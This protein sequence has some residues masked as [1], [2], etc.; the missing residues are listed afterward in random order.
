[1]NITIYSQPTCPACDQLKKEYKEKG[2]PFTEIIIGKDIAV[3]EFRELYPNVRSV[4]FV[5]TD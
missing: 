4:P 5:V 3:S 2:I 1:M